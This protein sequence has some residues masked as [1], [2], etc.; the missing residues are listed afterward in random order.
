MSST[1][2]KWSLDEPQRQSLLGVVVYIIRNFRVMITLFLSL[3]AVSISNVSLGLL[4]V[5][6][7]VPGSIL[8]TILAYYQHRNFTFHVEGDDLIIHRGVF[9]KDRLVVSV[10]RI[11]SI[12][13]TANVIQRLLG[14]VALKVDTAGSKG[15]EL[16][17][18]ALERERADI[19]KALL[20]R[21][22]EAAKGVEVDDVSISQKAFSEEAGKI[23]VR[24]NLFDLLKV[25]L[26]ENH[27]KTGMI[28]LAFV[29]GS[30]S[31]YQDFI[32]ENFDESI[33]E[34][35]VQ[36]FN[37]G[38]KVLLGFVMLYAVFSVLLSIGRT[39]LRFYGLKATLKQETVDISTGLLKKNHFR[40]P[41]S[42][43]QF[44]EW[45]NNPLRRAVGFESA[46][47]KPSSSIG[48]TGKQQRIEIPAL[49]T[50]KS[51]I[52]LEGVFGDFEE[53][54]NDIGIDAMAYARFS[55]VVSGLVF[56]SF[57]A[58]IYWKFG[59]YASIP[60]GTWLLIVV[61]SYFYGRSVE[62]SYGDDFIVIKKGFFFKQRVVIPTFKIQSLS[63]IQ[64]VFLKRRKLNH[65]RFYTAAGSKQVKYISN[66]EVELLYDH[67]LM[68]VEQSTAPWM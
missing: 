47:L 26:T 17:I 41:V 8:F 4:A 25:G 56:L 14:L 15:N 54:E 55:A 18:P 12:Q 10:D 1:E 30:I 35:S 65:I 51:W 16:E 67:L 45:S 40:I 68:R 44:I 60:I 21:K 31:Q 57:S 9:V 27:L 50:E 13:I 11:Q 33:D 32:K 46:I 2:K 42:K 52:L 43:V 39:L 5:S 64:N 36:V 22:K 63:R 29:F 38:I 6:V 49:R 24:L 62:L 20:Y 61:L 3:I 34:Y 48:E 28:A 37:S 23:L 66:K 58:L 53:P 7:L 59:W 19:L